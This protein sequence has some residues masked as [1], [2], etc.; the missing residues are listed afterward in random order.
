MSRI[1]VIGAGAWGTALAIQAAR[2]GQSVTLIARTPESARLIAT[3]RQNPRLPHLT[4]PPAIAVADSI[5]SDTAL[6]LWVVPMQQI[7]ASVST[8]RLPPVPVIVCAKGVELGTHRLPLEVMAEAAPACAAAFLGG[9]NFAH[10][11]ARGLPTAATL[12]SLDAGLRDTASALLATETFRLY[13]NDDP[14]GAQIGGA[15]K[16]VIA[17]AAGVV[18]GA[19]L[20]D[21]ARASLVTRGVAELGRL[22][23]AA[24]GKAETMMGLCGMGDLLLTC[25]SQ[26]SRNFS[27]GQALGQGR[28]LEQALAT[29]GTVE[30][31][32]TAGAL[33]ARAGN[34]DLPICQA[35]ADFL[36]GHETLESVMRRLLSRPRRDE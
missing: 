13:G 1:A 5:P 16:N 17:I 35:V 3:T 10:E 14:I 11:V 31:V 6:M 18:I 32:A 9:P 15:A 12:A 2:A 8:L 19:G 27:L 20:G 30:G 4:L 33:L 24:G 7:R 25:T 36:A 21:N 22:T 23:V 34:L 29:F 26:S 28:S